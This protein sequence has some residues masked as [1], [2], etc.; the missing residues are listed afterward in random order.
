MDYFEADVARNQIF[1]SSSRR[2]M[3]TLSVSNMIYHKFSHGAA[4]YSGENVNVM[5]ELAVM[6]LTVI[7]YLTFPA[8]EISYGLYGES[9]DLDRN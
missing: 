3:C 9:K 4:F 6:L 5:L 1:T 7:V 2:K 8:D